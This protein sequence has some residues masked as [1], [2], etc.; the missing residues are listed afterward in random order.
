MMEEGDGIVDE[1]AGGLA[2][3]ELLM[4]EE[5]GRLNKMD[6]QGREEC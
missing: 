5:C 2:A 3:A 6:N 4:S 1:K